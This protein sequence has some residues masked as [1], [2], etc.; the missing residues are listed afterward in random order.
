[1]LV[2][3][4]SQGVFPGKANGSLIKR[5]GVVVGSA[6]IGQQFY[7][8]V[9]GKNGKPEV[10]KGVVPDASPTRATSRRGRRAPASRTYR[11]ADNAAATTFS[12]LGPNDQATTQDDLQRNISAYLKLE[13]PYDPGLTVA[14]D[15]GRR[16]QQLGVGHRPRHLGRQR[17]HP[18]APRRR[19][20]PPLARDGRRA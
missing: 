7:E 15:P 9:I 5:D 1:M 12:N 20:A 18:G 14:H 16:R 19:R 8:P 2:T 13:K 4:V 6:L 11:G 10:V 3:G 17:R